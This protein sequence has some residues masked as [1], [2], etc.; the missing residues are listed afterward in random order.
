M[1]EA[2]VN[3]YSRL[4]IS[5][6]VISDMRKQFYRDLGKQPIQIA[7]PLSE[8]EYWGDILGIE[9]CHKSSFWLG[10]QT[11]GEMSQAAEQQWQPISDNEVTLCLKRMGNWK[12]PGPVQV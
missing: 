4:G 12:S 1:A 6:E 9:V 8:S 2:L 11:D 5:Q 7:S 3:I 10:C